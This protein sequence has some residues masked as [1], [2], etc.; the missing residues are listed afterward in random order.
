MCLR[1]S[2]P[3]VLLALAWAACVPNERPFTSG[4]PSPRVPVLYTHTYLRA[5]SAG[6]PALVDHV[7]THWFAMDSL[8]AADGLLGRYRLLRNAAAEP[9]TWDLIVEVGYYT[10]VGY[11]DIA[12]AFEAIREEYLSRYPEAASLEG[13]GRFIRSESVGVVP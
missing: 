7:G 11:E 12:E 2:L 5:D 9:R 6:L 3:T 8:A 10:P 13:L 4:G 1:R